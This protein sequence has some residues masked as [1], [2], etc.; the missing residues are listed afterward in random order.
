[1]NLFWVGLLLLLL[2]A[3]VLIVLE[4]DMASAIEM[5]VW[6]G[7]CPGD[8][9]FWSG[10]PIDVLLK[11]DRV[12]P[13]LLGALI[14]GEIGGDMIQVA[15]VSEARSTDA[16][17]FL[18]LVLGGRDDFIEGCPSPGRRPVGNL[19]WTDINWGLTLK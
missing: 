7:V 1:M 18:W 19:S 9:F 4:G 14:L 13:T 5:I 6:R 11:L 2:V 16:E 10:T 3:G 8:N 12:W 15:T 17:I